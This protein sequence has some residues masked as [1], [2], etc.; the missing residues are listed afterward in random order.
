MQDLKDHTY[1]RLVQ[2]PYRSHP[3]KIEQGQGKSLKV[4]PLGVKSPSASDTF[5]NS[6]SSLSPHLDTPLIRQVR[7][8]FKRMIG[9]GAFFFMIWLLIGVTIQMSTFFKQPVRHLRIEG[10]SLLSPL[11]LMQTI[12]LTP[13]QTL[14]SISP[15]QA[16]NDLLHHPLVKQ[17]QLRR[18]FPDTLYL[19]ILEH[20]PYAL[21]KTQQGHYLINRE[22]Y[23]LRKVSSVYALPTLVGVEFSELILGQPLQSLH[24][25]RGLIFLEEIRKK[26]ALEDLVSEVDVSD[27][28]NLKLHLKEKD[29]LVYLGQDHYLERMELFKKTYPQLKTR[30]DHITSIDLRYPNKITVIP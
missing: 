24:L 21:V 19:H 12:G 26:Y 22:Q 20:E 4:V 10:E 23:P 17:V 25:E 18:I 1:R 6:F 29:T 15:Y 14:G 30:Y 8:W 5:K 27:P 9:I 16:E 13:I 3:F 2:T 28:L 7:L 11:E